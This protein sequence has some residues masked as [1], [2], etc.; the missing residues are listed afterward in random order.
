MIAI[1]YANFSLEYREN[2]T[3]DYQKSKAI[4]IT[5]INSYIQSYCDKH[6]VS[7]S[8]FLNKIELRY[9]H[10]MQ[11]LAISQQNDPQKEK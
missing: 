10:L 6:G 8:S 9:Q 1:S 7:I 2:S 4:I 3:V 5:G 11:K